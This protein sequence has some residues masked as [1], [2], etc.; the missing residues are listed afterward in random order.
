MIY[1][2]FDILW[3]KGYDLTKVPLLKRKQ[4][5]SQILPAEGEVKYCDFY[6]EDAEKMLFDARKN[7]LEGIVAKKSDSL[8]YPGIRSK[9][10]LKIKVQK[11]HGVVI[12]GFTK[13]ENTPKLFSSVLVGFYEEDGLH[14]IEP[15]K[16]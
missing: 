14:Y 6:Y 10:W 2:V 3:F 1:Y 16:R 7:K 5:L 4:I 13:N 15:Q 8:Y 12:G 11:R 9:D